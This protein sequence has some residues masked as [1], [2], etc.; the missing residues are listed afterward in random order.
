M[1]TQGS[2]ECL[3]IPVILEFQQRN[4]R[5]RIRANRFWC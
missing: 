1:G 4:R 5:I 3:T 2:V